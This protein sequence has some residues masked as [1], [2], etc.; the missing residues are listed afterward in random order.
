MEG[1]FGKLLLDNIYEYIHKQRM[2]YII[3]EYNDL[4]YYDDSMNFLKK[5]QDEDVNNW[6]LYDVYGT[7]CVYDGRDKEFNWR[8][9]DQK[10]YYGN[11]SLIY[12]N[13]YVVVAKLP[14]NY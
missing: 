6:E 12:N 5:R 8:R 11:E 2:K 7:H 9:L 13:N 3:Q 10:I 4:F 14:K 1:K